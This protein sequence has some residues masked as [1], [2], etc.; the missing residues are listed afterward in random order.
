MNGK[1]LLVLLARLPARIWIQ[2]A[3]AILGFVVLAVLGFAVIAAVAVLGLVAI[4]VFKARAWLGA[5]FGG[6]G[7]L[8]ARPADRNVTDVKYEI[9]DPKNDR[10]R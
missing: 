6:R 1:Q 2:A 5:L 10:R 8:P 7:G 4:L 3:I 9:L